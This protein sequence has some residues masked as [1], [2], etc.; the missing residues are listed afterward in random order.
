MLGYYCEF[1]LCDIRYLFKFGIL[2]RCRI[3]V[4]VGTRIQKRERTI[5]KLERKLEYGQDH[6]FG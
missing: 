3:R 1:S 4:M 5:Y 6:R 2:V